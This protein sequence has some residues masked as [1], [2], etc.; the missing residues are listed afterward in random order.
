[1]KKWLVFV[2]TLSLVFTLTACGSAS[3]GSSAQASTKPDST[4]TP[5]ASTANDQSA[6][7]VTLRV[8]WWGSQTRHDITNKVIALYEQQHPNIKI[9][10]EF[11]GWS[12]YWEKLSAEVAGGQMPDIVQM[13]FGEYLTQY[14]NRGLLMDLNDLVKSGKIDASQVNKGLMDAGTVDGKL[15]GIPLAGNALGV[16]YDPEMIKAAGAN[17]PDINWTWDDYKTI[18]AKVHQK[19]GTYGT[20]VLEIGNV[21]EYYLRQNGY[22]M[23]SE[24]MTGLGYPDDK[25]LVDYFKMNLDLTNTG[26]AANLAVTTQIKAL[27][28]ELIVHKKSAFDFR[29]SNQLV[30]LSKA[31]QRPLS[32]ITFPGPNVDK[33][34]FLKPSMFFSMNKDTKHAAEAADF[35]NFFINN[36]DAGKLLG[37]ERGVPVA[38]AV[39]TALEA[40][41][42]P[43]E[44]QVFDYISLVEKHSSAL[45]SNYPPG[46]AEIM[47]ALTDINQKVMYKTITPEQGAK[48]FRDQT[49][50]IIARNKK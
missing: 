42:T 47:Q 3:G 2:L 25:M 19:F 26:V 27:E 14:A 11:T 33:G 15:L 49:A 29:W 48:Q 20:K 39:R 38:P 16:I 17:E 28:D 46:S 50:Q 10:P 21:F 23:F 24:D 6:K 18:A 35:I 8:M 45:D 43:V 44:K 40:N 32:I 1:M 9:E 5:A 30:A 37:T 12:G 4:A 7:P 41:L 31:A 13:N 36:V 22:K 34:M